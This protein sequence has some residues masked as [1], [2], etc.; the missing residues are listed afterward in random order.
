MGEVADVTEAF[1]LLHGED[2]RMV[3]VVLWLCGC[4]IDGSLVYKMTLCVC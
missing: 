3:Y 4:E 1:K 2:A